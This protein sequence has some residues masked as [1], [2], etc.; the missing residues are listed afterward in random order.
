[1]HGSFISL[2]HLI[3]VLNN[4][5]KIKSKLQEVIDASTSISVIRLIRVIRE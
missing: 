1:M 5:I 2:S 3:R 4:K